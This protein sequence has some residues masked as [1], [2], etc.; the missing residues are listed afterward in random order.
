MAGFDEKCPYCDR[1]IDCQ[2]KWQNTDYSTSFNTNCG[3]CTRP[4]QVC[5]RMEPI[6][7]TGKATCAMCSKA[8]VGGNGFYC[9]PC[10]QRMVDLSKFSESQFEG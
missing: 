1:E 10:H 8:D 9:D 4:V 2:A 3:W 7:E 5:V 6:F